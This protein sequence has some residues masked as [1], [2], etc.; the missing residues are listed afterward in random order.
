MEP[1]VARLPAASVHW[2]GG[3][4]E[5]AGRGQLRLVVWARREGAVEMAITTR[6]RFAGTREPLTHFPCSVGTPAPRL[7]CLPRGI[8]L[9]PRSEGPRGLSV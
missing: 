8:G 3:M 1:G 7:R 5:G 2:E 4:E 6:P 9:W